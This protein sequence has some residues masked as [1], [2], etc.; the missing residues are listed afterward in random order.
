MSLLPHVGTGP[1]PCCGHALRSRLLTRRRTV[2]SSVEVRESAS[3][4]G[5]GSAARGPAHEDTGPRGGAE[6]G[7][8][9]A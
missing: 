3:A 9:G 5:A 6:A 4:G 7:H 8:A 1:V 2:V